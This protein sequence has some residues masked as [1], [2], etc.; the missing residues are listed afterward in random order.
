MIEIWSESNNLVS[1]NIRINE[2]TVKSTVNVIAVDLNLWKCFNKKN[3]GMNKNATNVIL[4]NI[5]RLIT[6]PN[7]AIN[8][9]DLVGFFKFD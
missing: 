2:V 4:L 8:P 7:K 5:P 9:F 6:I 1:S 3:D